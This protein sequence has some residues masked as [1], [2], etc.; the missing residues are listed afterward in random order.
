MKLNEGGKLGDFMTKFAAEGL[1]LKTML[2]GIDFAGV[3]KH[4]IGAFTG[5]VEFIRQA[6]AVGDAASKLLAEFGDFD[7][8]AALR[9]LL[10]KGARE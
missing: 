3:V 2:A 9:P 1:N 4:L 8:L 10:D 7:P 6:K 5:G